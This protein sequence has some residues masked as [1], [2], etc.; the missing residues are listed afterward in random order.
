MAAHRMLLNEIHSRQFEAIDT[1]IQQLKHHAY[2][3]QTQLPLLDE[4][5]NRVRILC[6]HTT[7]YMN[8]RINNHVIRIM[9]FTLTNLVSIAGV[10]W[11]QVNEK[12]YLLATNLNQRFR[13]FA[14]MMRQHAHRVREQEL[15][16]QQ[17]NL[18]K[19]KLPT[20]E[21]Q[22]L[23]KSDFNKPL[24]DVCGICLEPHLMKESFTCNCRHSFGQK[25][26]KTWFQT[27]KKNVK[28][29]TCPTCRQ[30]VNGLVQYKTKL[31]V[32]KEKKD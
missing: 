11:A 27:C 19:K 5:S 15:K 30:N 31:P 21:I 22:V 26:F 8:P 18:R 25:C 14:L 17:A 3:R 20:P 10:A 2:Y 6:E 28:D 24:S 12:L 13:E 1:S 16:R 9:Q 32:K 29:L 23:S 4:I 7:H